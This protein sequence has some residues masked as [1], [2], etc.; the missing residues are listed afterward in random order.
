M[1]VHMT[2]PSLPERPSLEQLKKQAKTLL[3]HVHDGDAAARERFRVLPAFAR[4]PVAQF[5]A[6]QPA[7]HDAQGVIAREHGF[8]SWNSLRAEGLLATARLLLD[9]GA[10]ANAVYDYQWDAESQRTL[11]WGALCV[12]RH[13]ALA[14]LLLD[15]GADP[16]DGISLHG[17]AGTADLT[18]LELLER[19]HTRIDGIP[20]GVPPL[21][22]LFEWNSTDPARIHGIRCPGNDARVRLRSP[23]HRQGRRHCAAPRGNGG[24][25]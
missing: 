11:L 5:T 17:A 7:L 14:E 2:L 24:P 15:K 23:R 9:A 19:F 4:L 3:R 20:G 10:D 8:A 12:M 21:R 6:L 13:Y 16:T 1:E 18:A 22:Y 25:C